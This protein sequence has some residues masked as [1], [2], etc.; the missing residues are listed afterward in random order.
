[1]EIYLNGLAGKKPTVPIAQNGLEAAARE[2]MSREAFAYVAGGAGVE[3][4]LRENRAAFER[5]RIVPRM[6]RDV[7]NRDTSIELFGRR[8]PGPLL[9][10]P[11]GVLEMV[12]K[13][14]DVAVSKAAAAEGIPLKLAPHF[15]RWIWGNSPKTSDVQMFKPKDRPDDAAD[16]RAGRLSTARRCRQPPSPQGE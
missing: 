8:L 7:S 6:L 14:A 5:R 13:R 11:I 16:A 9:L 1:M 15:R 3:S 10:A 12:H 2:K 4:T